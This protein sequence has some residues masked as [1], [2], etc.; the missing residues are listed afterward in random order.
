MVSVKMFKRQYGVRVLVVT[1]QPFHFH[2]RARHDVSIL[3]KAVIGVKYCCH[4]HTAL[5]RPE[6]TFSFQNFKDQSNE[7]QHANGLIVSLI[8]LPP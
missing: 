1:S 2:L 5:N 7:Q 4:K 6:V 3:K 8:Y